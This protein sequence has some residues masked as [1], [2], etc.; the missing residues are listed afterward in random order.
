MAVSP[1]SREAPTTPR[2]CGHAAPAAGLGVGP[3]QRRDPRFS[4]GIG[5]AASPRLAPPTDQERRGSRSRPGGR[6][7]L[8]RCERLP[9]LRSD[10]RIHARKEKP[11][12]PALPDDREAALTFVPALDGLREI[13]L[14]P[15]VVPTRTSRA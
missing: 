12:D 7:R 2:V 6:L 13:A 15:L 4:R 14:P 5:A 9:R 1:M 3:D 10:A 8:A 11:A